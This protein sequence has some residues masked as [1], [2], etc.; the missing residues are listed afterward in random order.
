MVMRKIESLRVDKGISAEVMA[1][2]FGVSV[3]TIYNWQDN[4]TNL[5]GDKIIKICEYFNI[6]ANDFLGIKAK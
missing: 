1:K 5:S 2:D 3:K 6:T 4:Q